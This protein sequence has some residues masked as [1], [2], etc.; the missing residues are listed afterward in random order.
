MRTLSERRLTPVSRGR[1]ILVLTSACLMTLSGVARAQEQAPAPVASEAPKPAK[2][3]PYSLPW[4]LRPVAP[5]NVVRL[6]SS[7][8]DDPMKK[9]DYAIVQLD[10]PISF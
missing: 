7:P 8:I 3:P 1:D 5:A 2:A 10:L 6:D 4:Q 9:A